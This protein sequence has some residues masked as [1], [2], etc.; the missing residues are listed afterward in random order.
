[1]CVGITDKKSL[2]RKNTKK[3]KAHSLAAPDFG[4][5]CMHW[6]DLPG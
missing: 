3:Q 5:S 1:M 6:A 2:Q 4:Q